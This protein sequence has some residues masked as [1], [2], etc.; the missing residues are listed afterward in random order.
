MM[1]NVVM[2]LFLCISLHN[3]SSLEGFICGFRER[4]LHKARFMR[5]NHFDVVRERCTVS[6][7]ALQL[8]RALI[9]IFKTSF[10]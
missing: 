10:C 8:I 7:I 6:F 1:V 5:E 4:R 9:E 2:F 3:Y